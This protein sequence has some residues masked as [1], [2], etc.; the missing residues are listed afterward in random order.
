MICRNEYNRLK[1][2]LFLGVRESW[3]FE[4]SKYRNLNNFETEKEFLSLPEHKNTFGAKYR[5]VY[6]QGNI[7]MAYLHHSGKLCLMNKNNS[8]VIWTAI[9]NASPVFDINNKKVI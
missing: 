5:H 3:N 9:K 7:Y 8:S 4:D 2:E 6:Y 1:N